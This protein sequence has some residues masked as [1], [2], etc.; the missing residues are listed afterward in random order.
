MVYQDFA[1]KQTKDAIDT[2]IDFGLRG[3]K[4][5]HQ[6]FAELSVALF[7]S[8]EEKVHAYFGP[9]KPVTLRI[10][11]NHG[12]LNGSWWFIVTAVGGSEIYERK[13]SLEIILNLMDVSWK[14]PTPREQVEAVITKY[15]NETDP[16]PFFSNVDYFDVIYSK[17][18]SHLGC[19]IEAFLVDG[20]NLVVYLLNGDDRVGLI[21]S[22]EIPGLL[23]PIVVGAK[24]SSTQHPYSEINVS[25]LLQKV[26]SIGD[27]P[28][29]AG[30]VTGL[31]RENIFRA[32]KAYL[33]LQRTAD[34]VPFTYNV[35]W[36]TNTNLLAPQIRCVLPA[37]L[38]PIVESTAIFDG[39]RQKL[40]ADKAREFVDTYSIENIATHIGVSVTIDHKVTQWR[41]AIHDLSAH[42]ARATPNIADPS[43]TFWI[44]PETGNERPDVVED[45]DEISKRVGQFIDALVPHEGA[46]K[47]L[48]EMQNVL[49]K[50]WGDIAVKHAR[51]D[52]PVV[53][54]R[55]AI[56]ALMTDFA[57]WVDHYGRGFV[58]DG[59]SYA[60][61]TYPSE[62]AVEFIIRKWDTGQSEAALFTFS[63]F[64]PYV[65]SGLD[66]H[67]DADTFFIPRQG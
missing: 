2:F 9:S 56:S 8:V 40:S 53:L 11:K 31:A 12:R 13:V 6:Y 15:L 62:F 47:R 45:Q 29:S 18:S 51:G 37:N 26:A 23:Q 38:A 30:L 10:E 24:D 4:N 21:G 1:A 32:I 25:A 58:V 39:I 16:T 28:P 65:E 64:H 5:K 42:S 48:D 52:F 43:Q 63:L 66:W 57:A 17:V 20:K 55:R 61:T 67:P 49:A 33:R 50:M 41:F 60:A 22:W 44:V 36:E 34:I 7:N 27:A 59:D 46:P 14:F 19:P 54:P 35:T 3:L